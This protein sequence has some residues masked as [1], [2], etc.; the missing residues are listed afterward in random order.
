MTKR[1]KQTN[2]LACGNL[3]G[4]RV[5]NAREMMFGTRD[6]FHYA[7]CSKC[8]ALQITDP[9]DN[10]NDYYPSNY[11]SFDVLYVGRLRRYL[12]GQRLRNALGCGGNVGWFLSKVFGLQRR[13]EWKSMVK[14][15]YDDRILDVG[16]GN[17]QLL[18]ELHEAGFKG[19]AGLDPYSAEQRTRQGFSIHRCQLN[20]WKEEQD[21]VMMHHSFEHMSEPTSVLKDLRRILKPGGSIL[22]RTPVANCLAWRSY[23]PHWV[24]L[25]APRHLFIPSIDG[26]KRLAENAGL[27]VIDIQFDSTEF[28]FW[29]SELYQRDI[30]LT[31]ARKEKY[32][33]RAQLSNFQKQAEALNRKNDGDSACFLLKEKQT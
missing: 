21:L 15:G 19:I 17:G 20:E 32:F 33:S 2:C 24:Q 5:F 10:L 16:C 8:K 18:A 29:G 28:Q 4:N 13:S 1:I 6:V 12:R 26:M 14:I 22:I 23:G 30:P 31:G 3:E 25:D 11:Y 9:P 27:S 7:E